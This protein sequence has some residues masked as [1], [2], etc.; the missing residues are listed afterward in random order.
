MKFLILFFLFGALLFS[1][2]TQ[3][4]LVENKTEDKRLSQSLDSVFLSK[5][6]YEY[7]IRLN[8]KISISVWGQDE[9]SVGSI[10]GVYNSNEIYGK[11]LMVDENGKIEVPKIGP[12]S[13]L[14][15]TTNQLKDTLLNRFGEW[16]KNPIIDI[17]IMNKEVTVL[18]E[19]RAPQSF[20]IDKDNNNLFEMISKSGGFEFYANLKKIK[21]IRQIGD[22]THV[23]QIDI[24]KHRND[25]YAKNIQIY[26]GDVIIVPSK[27]NKEFDKRVSTLIPFTASISAIAVFYNLFKK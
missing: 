10:Y 8:D 9:L 26:P 19:V 2:S 1:C 16:I 13:V 21:V 23:A 7:K 24:S 14:N 22:S 18:G 20:I 4:I 5:E 12:L 3:N 11:W 17:K 15:H 25:Y 27:K 6:K